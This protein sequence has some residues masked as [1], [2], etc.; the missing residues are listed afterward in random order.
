MNVVKFEKTHCFK[1]HQRQ[2]HQNSLLL[3]TILW[4]LNDK[5]TKKQ[6]LIK[7]ESPKDQVFVQ[8]G[9]KF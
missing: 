8:D 6:I 3:Q 2:L 9:L 4:N 1:L 7:K 5:T